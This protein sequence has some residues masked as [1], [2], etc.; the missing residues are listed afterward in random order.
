MRQA[1]RKKELLEFL[2]GHSIGNLA[3]HD[4]TQVN[5]ATIFFAHESGVLFFKSRTASRH[6][7][8]AETH[9]HAAISVYA[10]DSTYNG[11]YGVQ[12]KGTVDRIVQPDLMA[13]AVALYS[14]KFQGAGD[15][16]PSLQELCGPE[17]A[18]TFYQF[19]IAEFKIID[20]G[21]ERNRT[22]SN[23]EVF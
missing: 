17:I 21:K 6:S 5:L 7:Q 9:A 2:D 1:D 8:Q 23:Y 20:E 12:L 18:S 16:L 13:K 14:N 4:G 15:K 10:H 3:T 11:K 19:S 22:M